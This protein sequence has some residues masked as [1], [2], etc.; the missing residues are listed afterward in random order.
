MVGEWGMGTG[1]AH[2]PPPIGRVAL[3]KAR[4]EESSIN[5]SLRIARPTGHLRSRHSLASLQTL[6]ALSSAS[7]SS[8]VK[9]SII[10]MRINELKP[11]TIH[12]LP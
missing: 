1:R 4:N 9:T 2:D 5:T 12:C 8:K 11:L 10:P 7:L 6:A 3:P